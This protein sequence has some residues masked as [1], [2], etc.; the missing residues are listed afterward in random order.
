MTYIITAILA[1]SFIFKYLLLKKINKI[2]E[3]NQQYRK[4]IQNALGALGID[5]NNFQARISRDLE[6]QKKEMEISTKRIDKKVDVSNRDIIN[7]LPTKI[8][9][10]IGHIEFSSRA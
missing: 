4:S 7:S 6:N 3:E 10:V 9:K 2:K 5:I 1:S 8:R